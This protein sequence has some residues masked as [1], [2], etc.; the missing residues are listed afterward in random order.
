ML[1]DLTADLKQRLA[2]TESRCERLERQLEARRSG[3]AFLH[4]DSGIEERSGM[5]QGL[6]SRANAVLFPV[7]CI[8][9]SAMLLVKRICRQ[10][11]KRV[12]PSRSAGLASFCVAL[13]YCA[14]RV[15][16]DLPE[17]ASDFLWQYACCLRRF[18]LCR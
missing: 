12:L 10:S 16:S 2:T 4:H 18:S 8:S 7:D 15:S 6:V 5:L 11:G 3:A 14:Q 17:Q 13:R 9:H 1:L